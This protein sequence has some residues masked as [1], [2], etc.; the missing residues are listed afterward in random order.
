MLDR[1]ARERNR[2]T[3]C[4]KFQGPEFI[5]SYTASSEILYIF[6]RNIALA[7]QAPPLA[8][9]VTF[10]RADTYTFNA[11]SQFHGEDADKS[12]AFNSLINTISHAVCKHTRYVISTVVQLEMLFERTAVENRRSLTST[13]STSRST[14]KTSTPSA[15]AIP[16][17]LGYTATFLLDPR[18]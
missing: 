8:R 17:S 7:S 12:D 11:L 15:C 9:L 13:S 6:H 1:T 14:S 16:E 2:T 18:I 4:H 3:N 5:A 10:H